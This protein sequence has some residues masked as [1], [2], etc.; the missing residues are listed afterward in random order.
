MTGQ[1]EGGTRRLNH[2]LQS[3]RK[4]EIE[5]AGTYNI[6]YPFHIGL[7]NSRG[8]YA[9][10]ING[11]WLQLFIPCDRMNTK[12]EIH[13]DAQ[14]TV[15]W[16][17]SDRDNFVLNHSGTLEDVYTQTDVLENVG[18]IPVDSFNQTE[19]TANTTTGSDGVID[20]SFTGSNVYVFDDISGF[21]YDVS[22]YLFTDLNKCEQLAKAIS[23]EASNM[24]LITFTDTGYTV[25]G[26]TIIFTMDGLKDILDKEQ[27]Y[28]IYVRLKVREYSSVDFR[29]YPHN[30]ETSILNYTG[31]GVTT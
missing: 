17:G 12:A 22:R 4:K 15:T 1:L 20:G 25:N 23:L 8:Q 29:Y 28:M 9:P 24:Q 2:H 30:S 26:I 6:K 11:F 5:V 7:E 21:R 31:Y 19:T 10:R 13:F 27:K 14:N 18:F 16:A 3:G